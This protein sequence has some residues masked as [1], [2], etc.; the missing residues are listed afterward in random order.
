MRKHHHKLANRQYI[1]RPT[2]M[3]RLVKTKCWLSCHRV[4]SRPVSDCCAHGDVRCLQQHTRLGIVCKHYFHMKMW[5]CGGMRYLQLEINSTFHHSVPRYLNCTS[6]HQILHIS[7]STNG[8]GESQKQG[9]RRRVVVLLSTA[10]LSLV[11]L[12]DCTDIQGWGFQFTKTWPSASNA[13]GTAKQKKFLCI[14]FRAFPILPRSSCR[15]PELEQVNAW[16]EI[17]GTIAY[18]LLKALSCVHA[19]LCLASAANAHRE[20]SNAAV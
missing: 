5:I 10:F 2:Q 1:R 12:S 17:R 9:N 16:E 6:F 15:T 18:H 14:I 3:H 13:S 8:G 19:F 7:S 11:P 4:R 20:R